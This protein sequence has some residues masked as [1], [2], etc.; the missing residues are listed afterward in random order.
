MCYK[1][2]KILTYYRQFSSVLNPKESKK[3]DFN[4]KEK[5]LDDIFKTE[6]VQDKDAPEI[7]AIWQEYHKDKKVICATIPV[8]LYKD[9]KEQMI[10]YPIFIVPLP[11][12]QGYEFI[13]SQ[14][15]GHTV[16]FTPLL[17][18]QVFRSC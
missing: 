18:Y 14:V 12:S 13:M 17:A 11:R 15:D 8:D 1:K 9:V 3:G 16:H 6:L 10:L 7:Q 2:L 5:C 4:V